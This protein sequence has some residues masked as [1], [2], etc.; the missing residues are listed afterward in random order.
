MPAIIFLLLS[1]ASFSHGNIAIAQTH[2]QVLNIEADQL[3]L[4]E[5]EGRSIYSGHVKVSRGNLLVKGDKLILQTS[6]KKVLQYMH[7]IGKPASFEQLNQ[8]QQIISASAG[9][10][11]YQHD[12]GLLTL[13]K[14][15]VLIRNKNT[16]RADKI[17]YNTR[18]DIVQAGQNNNTS[19]PKKERVFITIHPD[20]SKA[21][22]AP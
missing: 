18:T 5:K 16:F 9:E 6:A 19:T 14:D 3:T 20:D 13:T 17:I 8:Q 7:V 10:L 15:A 2:N 21:T 22:D 4:N 1:I 11:L 12:S